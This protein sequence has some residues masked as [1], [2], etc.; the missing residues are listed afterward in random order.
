MGMDRTI[1]YPTGSVPGWD[2]IRAQLGRLGVTAPLRMIDGIPA[3]PDETPDPGWKELRVGV[4]GG[5]VTL[6]VSGDALT[7]VVW[8]NAAD[9]LREGWDAVCW[10][11]AAAGGGVV[12]TP[13]GPVGAAEFARRAGLQ[14]A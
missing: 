3:F 6:R 8:G 12:D 11:C 10:A 14:P 9:D 2:T 5:M 1:R 7:C 4:P 13:Q